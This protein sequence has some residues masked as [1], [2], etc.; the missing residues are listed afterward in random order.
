MLPGDWPLLK[1]YHDNRKAGKA[2]TFIVKPEA[3]CQ[4]RGIYLTRHIDSTPHFSQNSRMTSVSFSDICID[5]S[6]SMDSSLIWEF[7][8]WWQE[9]THSES[10]CTSKAWLVLRQSLTFLPDQT[11][12]RTVSCT[13][14][15]TLLI[16]TVLTL[17]LMRQSKVWLAWNRMRQGP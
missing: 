4:G 15:T 3:A 11:I 6:L 1:E 7:M 8:C 16:K 2:Q 12:S 17:C 5:P 14:P 13:W 9:L 10:L